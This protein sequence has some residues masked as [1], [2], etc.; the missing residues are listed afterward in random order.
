MFVLFVAAQ[1]AFWTS[2]WTEYNTGILKTNVGQFGV[3]ESEMITM[4]IHIL[5]GIF[6]QN[7][8]NIH[9]IDFLPVA[10]TSTITN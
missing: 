9:I 8:W 6:G 2:N 10:F 4:V 5:T 1:F 3:T 7:V